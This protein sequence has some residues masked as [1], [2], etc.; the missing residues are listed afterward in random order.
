M[1]NQSITSRSTVATFLD[2]KKKLTKYS[3]EI[4]DIFERSIEDIID[5]LPN[6]DIAYK[7]LSLLIKLGLGYL[8]LERKTQTLSTGEFQCVHLVSELFANTRNP[9]TLFIFDEPSKGLSQ[10]ILNQFIDSVRGILQDESV[11]I[12]MIEHNSYMLESSDYIVDFGKRQIGA[13]NHLEVVSHDDYYRQRTSVNNVEQIHITSAL[14]PKEGVHYLEGNHINYFKN[15]ENVYKGGI[16]KSL[17]S[18]ARLIYGEY[19]SNT[20]AP[21]IAIDLEKHLYSQY[22]FY[23]RLVE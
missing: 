1:R 21:V 8:T 16:L 22:S 15:A 20:I 19:E 9:H 5:E 13:I 14:K 18:M 4:D 23:M 11:S 6:E 2:I 3:E 12:I 17:S 7:R 10:N